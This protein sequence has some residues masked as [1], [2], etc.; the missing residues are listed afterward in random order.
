MQAVNCMQSLGLKKR[1]LAMIDNRIVI[2]S[3][4]EDIKK[5][6]Q[7]VRS[8]DECGEDILPGE[9]YYKIYC[10]CICEECLKGYMNRHY[11]VKAGE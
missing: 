2:E 5:K 7:P 8:C 1:S 6:P 3:E 4:W 11:S 9:V 10:D